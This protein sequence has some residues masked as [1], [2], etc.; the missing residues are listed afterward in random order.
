M[1]EPAKVVVVGGGA[2]GL[3]AALWA[4]RGLSRQGPGSNPQAQA[5]LLEGGSRCGVK[6]AASG[7]G[8]CNIL[9]TDADHTDFHTAGSLN[10]LKRLLR[11]WRLQD[12]N[13][14]FEHDLGLP[15]KECDDGKQFPECE[16]ASQ[17]RDQIQDSVEKEGVEVRQGWK[18]S[19]IEKTES[20]FRVHSEDGNQID[21][22]KL[23]LACGGQSV[24]ASGSDGSGYR[25]AKKL[26]HSLVA[27]YP[28]LVPLTSKDKDFADLSGVAVEVT[29]RAILNKRVQEERTRDLL[30]THH[31]FSGPAILDASHWFTRDNATIQVS[32]GG[33]PAEEWE[34]HLNAKSRRDLHKALSDILPKR[35]ANLL[36]EK[37][38]LRAEMRCGNLSRGQR[39][40]LVN[41]LCHFQLPINGHAGFGV[42]EVTGG[43]I[44]LGEVNPSTLESRA[45]PGLFLCGE[46]LDC[47]GRMGGFNF[48]WAWITGRLA[49]ESAAK[50]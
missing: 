49:G 7:G 42:A 2:A 10:V 32:W 22:I 18:V 40:R 35:L 14:F 30:I 24:P 28:A 6:I 44:P 4:A 19:L 43:G 8:R 26:G 41:T 21:C 31:G 5:V 48:L 27:P 46:M 37:V 13:S 15:L 12:L 9:P 1:S 16:S 39:I 25:L 11:T 3:M 33:G 17:V 50:S 20:G 29:W 34:A 45:S 23:I 36:I 47:T 38:G